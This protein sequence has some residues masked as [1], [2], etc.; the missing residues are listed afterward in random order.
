MFA[1]QAG[2]SDKK[3]FLARKRAAELRNSVTDFAERDGEDDDPE[4]PA[5]ADDTAE[6]AGIRTRSGS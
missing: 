1:K 6:D 5:T 4:S 3:L 2:A